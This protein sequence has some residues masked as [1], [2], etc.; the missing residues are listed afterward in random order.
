MDITQTVLDLRPASVINDN[1]FQ[2]FRPKE[3][4]HSTTSAMDR[5]DP[6]LGGGGREETASGCNIGKGGVMMLTR[7]NF[8]QSLLNSSFTF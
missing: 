2:F 7:L 6:Q 3:E 8:S 4:G 5:M 1:Y